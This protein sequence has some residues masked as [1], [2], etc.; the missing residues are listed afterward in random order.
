MGLLALATALARNHRLV[1]FCILWFFVHLAVESSVVSLEMAFE[2]RLYLPMVGCALLASSL[3]FSRSPRRPSWAVAFALCIVA[4]LGAATYTRNETWRD[5][6]TLWSDVL[7]KN[8]RSHRGHYNLGVQLE[9]LGRIDEAA[10]HYT[11]AIRIAPRF[12]QA[13]NNL[14]M[15]L[16]GKGSVRE[17]IRHYRAALEVDPEFAKAHNN[18]AMAL[19]G[20][21]RFD[22]AERHYAEALR[23]VPGY[24]KAH[25]NLGVTLARQ[26][27]LEE[28]R[29]QFAEALR[30]E[31]D[32]LEARK[33]LEQASRLLTR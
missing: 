18:L 24:A 30:I 31:P 32:Y 33:N 2:H 13:H 4:A 9:A 10:R 28:A 21:G 19:S 12:E 14:G 15:A 23:L 6:V 26:G 3:L 22:E 17:A 16:A 27:R 20:Q 25:N 8:P 11:E 1:S 7:A 29:H 5:G